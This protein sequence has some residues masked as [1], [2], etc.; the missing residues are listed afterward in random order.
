MAKRRE[1]TAAGPRRRHQQVLAQRPHRRAVDRPEGRDA[2][3]RQQGPEPLKRRDI[4]VGQPPHPTQ[5][6]QS[7]AAPFLQRVDQRLGVVAAQV[8]LQL[9]QAWQPAGP[10]V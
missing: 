3:R 5:R 6:G 4:S 7:Q 9:H 8:R 1:A 10:E 2:V